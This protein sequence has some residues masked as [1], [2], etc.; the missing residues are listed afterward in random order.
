M[1]S[2]PRGGPKNLGA[3]RL[4]FRARPWLSATL[5]VRS[6]GQDRTRNAQTDPSLAIASPSALGRSCRQSLL[7]AAS[8]TLAAACAVLPV[9][10]IRVHA[11][12]LRS[13]PDE[14]RAA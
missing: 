4:R 5:D 2:D 10:T 6:W 3:P 14:R 8:P 7:R 9:L 12:A 1:I 13:A 11:I